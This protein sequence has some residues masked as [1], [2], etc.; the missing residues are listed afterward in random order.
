MEG[1]GV[2]YPY[3]VQMKPEKIQNQIDYEKL[4]ELEPLV[5]K[6]IA[7]DGEALRELCEEVGRGILF[8]IN[9]ILGSNL[10]IMDAEDIS[11][12]V[13][14]RICESITT[15]REPKYFRKW[16][17]SIISNEATQ[18]LR[19]KMKK[20]T[21]LDI[22]DYYEDIE[23]ESTDFIPEEYVNDG[24]LREMMMGIISTLPKRQ[25]EAIIYRYYDD[26]GVTEVAEA[27]KITQPVASRYLS[28]AVEKIKA[29]IEK[30]PSAMF[31][32]IAPAVSIES[33]LRETLQADAAY[34]IP[35]HPDWLQ[36]ALTPCEQY[37]I[38]GSALIT[39]GAGVATAT[40]ATAGAATAGAAATA[41]TAATSVTATMIASIALTCVLLVAPIVA[42]SMEPAGPEP[43]DIPMMSG[44]MHFYG[45][46]DL[47]EHYKRINPRSARPNVDKDMQI[48]EWWIVNEDNEVVLRCND[49]DSSKKEVQINPSEFESNGVYYIVFIIENDQGMSYTMGSSFLIDN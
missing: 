32:G 44:N 1:C 49:I 5:E 3:R 28:I 37:F 6:A 46:I 9:R 2:A 33:L 15:L 48:L 31:F 42:Y 41:A 13:F 26:L 21:M 30:M 36:I 19:R 35:P 29:E 12:E 24:E 39:G 10:S 47:G 34:F 38:A 11:R 18:F 25:R 4:A 40:T 27:M 8:R 7:G 45:G 43:I 22:N 14:L 23:D 16:L 20:G 17:N